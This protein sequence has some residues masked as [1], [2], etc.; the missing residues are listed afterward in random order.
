MPSTATGCTRVL[1]RGTTLHATSSYFTCYSRLV[2]LFDAAGV[3][4]NFSRLRLAKHHRVVR[5]GN[6]RVFGVVQPPMLVR[7]NAPRHCQLT[8]AV[9]V[10]GA[11]RWHAARAALDEY[12]ASLLG[13]RH[14]LSLSP[15]RGRCGVFCTSSSFSRCPRTPPRHLHRLPAEPCRSD[16]SRYTCD[17]LPGLA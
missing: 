1:L 12:T 14:G 17:A 13:R 16:C 4:G 11:N 10:P 2:E 8:A 9:P 3:P 6:A 15:G 7:I 5:R